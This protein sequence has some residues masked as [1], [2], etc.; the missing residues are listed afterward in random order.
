MPHFGEATYRLS[1][2]ISALCS[3]RVLVCVRVVP[4]PAQ[5]VSGAVDAERVFHVDDNEVVVTCLSSRI[6]GGTEL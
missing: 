3:E 1:A 2:V 6:G 5:E 4:V